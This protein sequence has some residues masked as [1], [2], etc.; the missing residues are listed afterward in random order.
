M[1]NDLESTALD[2]PVY[3]PAR[4]L[5]PGLGHFG[6]L[7]PE[8]R[9]KI[10]QEYFNLDSP[11]K[12]TYDTLA[13]SAQ[14]SSSSPDAFPAIANEK[15]KVSI[16]RTSGQLYRETLGELYHHRNLSICFDRDHRDHDS[17]S[18]NCET[19]FHTT[20]NGTCISRDFCHTDFSRFESIS[21]SVRIPPNTDFWKPRMDDINLEMIWEGFKRFCLLVRQCQCSK[22]PQ[23]APW[24]TFDVTVRVEQ[25]TV[26]ESG[27]HEDYIRCVLVSL[28]VLRLLV[29]MTI[30]ESVDLQHTTV[31]VDLKLGLRKNSW[32]TSYVTRPRTGVK[33]LDSFVHSR[34]RMTPPKKKSA[35]SL[36][37][38]ASMP[39]GLFLEC[40]PA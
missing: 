34:T 38:Y 36:C 23:H 12:S 8:I 11:A 35:L 33:V 15:R 9:S 29:E 17:T 21:L 18:P 10:W 40:L 25:D 5:Q 28:Y 3:S 4:P 27:P 13:C 30:L 37:T 22:P 16:L 1:A 7:P 14:R 6:F 26:G 24:P 31:N 32:T 2:N 39:M 19:I 20:M